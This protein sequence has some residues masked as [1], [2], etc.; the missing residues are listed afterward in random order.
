MYKQVLPIAFLLVVLQ[1]A[2]AFRI[3]RPEC[4]MLKCATNYDPVCGKDGITYD[5]SCYLRSF[6]CGKIKMDY[7]GECVR[8][9]TTAQPCGADVMCTMEYMPVCGSDGVTYSNQCILKTRTCG[10]GVT[11]EHEGECNANP[12][13]N[14]MRCT[15]EKI[16]VCGSDGVTYS[17]RCIFETE[18]CGQGVTL[19]HEGE[20][21]TQRPCDTDT[22]CTF[23]YQPVC[24][25]DGVTY[26]NA[27][28]FNTQ[29]CGTNATVVHEGACD[30]PRPCGALRCTFIDQP[31][32]GSDGQTYPNKCLFDTETCG[33][34][35]T[36]A[37]EGACVTVS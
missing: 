20:C 35:A 15:R 4:P 32:C 27:C 24:G 30:T 3:R 31:V 33:T 29:T 22:F 14:A 9:I 2:F 5:N 16:P 23:D 1:N 25:S 13:C 28:S 21:N 36:V 17:N 37:H 7:A 34:N 10:Q 12:P 11:L 26:P 6:T 8:Q 18:T 19:A